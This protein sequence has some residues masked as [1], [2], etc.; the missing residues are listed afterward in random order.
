M[1]HLTNES[2]GSLPVKWSSCGKK[3]VM[4][5]EVGE[6]TQ[7]KP[8]KMMRGYFKQKLFR[9]GFE[10]VIHRKKDTQIR[11]SWNHPCFQKGCRD[12]VKRILGRRISVFG[13]KDLCLCCHVH[14]LLHLYPPWKKRNWN[15]KSPNHSKMVS[16]MNIW[17]VSLS[18]HLPVRPMAGCFRRAN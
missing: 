10:E 6:K 12:L 5:K 1:D 14:L 8:F 2:K 18:L 9:L 11:Y 7:V 17:M 3:I 15:W 4:L 13:E 16:Y